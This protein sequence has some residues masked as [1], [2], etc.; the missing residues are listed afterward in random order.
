MPGTKPTR[1]G[2]RVLLLGMIV[3]IF[4]ASA[5]LG[6][7]WNTDMIWQL[8][9]QPFRH[10]MRSPAPG[11]LPVVGGELR[12]SDGDLVIPNPPRPASTPASLA[13]GQQL[14][15][16]YC[17]VCHGED[18]LG[19]G[20]VGVRFPMPAPSLLLERPP[21]YIYSK[22]RNGSVFM[23]SYAEHLSPAES[24]KVVNYL[25]GLEEEGKD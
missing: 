5:A 20:P 11:T 19:S 25:K 13:E 12:N 8:A 15:G 9:L 24:W 6:F 17:A 3:L 1:T 21:Q 2:R 10:V 18:A 4:G 14:F 22:I 16:I 7:P 23:P